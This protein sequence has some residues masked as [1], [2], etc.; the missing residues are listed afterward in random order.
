MLRHISGADATRCAVGT[1]T[2]GFYTTSEAREGKV[3]DCSRVPVRVLEHSDLG[4]RVEPHV[5]NCRWAG[6]RLSR[7]LS[8][9]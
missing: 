1:I 5:G 8:L 4:K 2:G 7:S 6:V 3:A 9:L